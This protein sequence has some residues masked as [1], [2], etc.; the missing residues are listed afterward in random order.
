[1]ANS[2][3]NRIKF[4]VRYMYDIDNNGYLDK[5]DFDC[6]AVKNTIME[7]KGSWDEEKYKKNKEVMKDLW[8]Q[9]AEIAD[10]DKN[11]EVD[12][13]E[14]INGVET[15]CKGKIYDQFPQAFKFFIESSFRTL[16]A[17]GDGCVGLEEYRYDCVSRMAYAS[18]NDLN[19]AY[20]KILND[21][22]KKEG[23]ITLERYKE[24]YAQFLGN[25]DPTCSACYL[26]GP[27]PPIE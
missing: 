2:W 25:P 15:A 3:D 19:E 5:N 26:F 16:D 22:D 14:F 4:I 23:G 11:G 27:L 1:M 7:G 13:G 24:L 20:E 6:L 8:D 9:I 12:T 21:A 17:D 10:F 18:V